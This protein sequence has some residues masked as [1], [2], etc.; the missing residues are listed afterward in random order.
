MASISPSMAESHPHE[1]G[2]HGHDRFHLDDESHTGHGS[3][4]SFVHERT[5]TLEEEARSLEI[6]YLVQTSLKGP[7]ESASETVF[8]DTADHTK[9]PRLLV[10]LQ[11]VLAMK[12][13]C[14]H[15]FNTREVLS[16][17]LA[18][19]RSDYYKEL[20]SLREQLYLASKSQANAELGYFKAFEVYWF[21]PPKYIDLDLKEY[22]ENAIK[23]Q[24]RNL[25][26]ENRQLLMKVEGKEDTMMDPETRIK[27]V[28]KK[29]GSPVRL[30]KKLVQMVKTGVLL[31]VSPSFG[32]HA[33]PMS[34]PKATDE[35]KPT[36]PPEFSL[37]ELE[38]AANEAFP[39]ALLAAQRAKEAAEAEAQKAQQ[40]AQKAAEE[41]K[42]KS[43]QAALA[44]S[45][46]DL[47]PVQKATGSLA[48]A[49]ADLHVTVSVPASTSL[50]D[51]SEKEVGPYSIVPVLQELQR[52]IEGLS[53]PLAQVIEDKRQAE[54]AAKYLQ[55][56]QEQAD[57]ELA[58]LTSQ[59]RQGGFGVHHGDAAQPPTRQP[60]IATSADDERERR[61]REE[62]EK[63]AGREK[64]DEHRKEFAAER[65][66]L[67]DELDQERKAAAKAGEEME[68]VMARLAQAQDKIKHLKAE[69]KEW[70]AK[71]G[72]H[73]ESEEEEEEEEVLPS[74]LLSY[75]QRLALSN[76]PRWMHLAEDAKLKLLRQQHFFE[77]N[78]FVGSGSNL[79]KTDPKAAAKSALEF[80]HGKKH[81]FPSKMQVPPGM[82]MEQL[83]EMA[84]SIEL[85]AAKPQFLS[86]KTADALAAEA[87]SLYQLLAGGTAASLL[88]DQVYS[89]SK[90]KP[91][92][93][94]NSPQRGGEATTPVGGGG[95]A[96][97]GVLLKKSPTAQLLEGSSEYS[98]P[99][100][101]PAEL[102]VIGEQ[103]PQSREGRLLHAMLQT[104]QQVA[105]QA[106]AVASQADSEPTDSE[107]FSPKRSNSPSS[108]KS[109]PQRPAPARLRTPPP[110]E[111]AEEQERPS[112][113]GQAGR[114]I[115]APQ[116]KARPTQPTEPRPLLPP[117]EPRLPQ[118][119][120]PLKELLEPQLTVLS[121]Q[122]PPQFLS[123]LPGQ[124]QPDPAPTRSP[125]RSHGPAP[126]RPVPHPEPVR[127]SPSPELELEITTKSLLR[128]T[129]STMVPS[130]PVSPLATFAAERKPWR[131][132]ASLPGSIDQASPSQGPSGVEPGRPARQF[133][134]TLSELPAGRSQVQ[135]GRSLVD[136]SSTWSPDYGGKVDR[137]TGASFV[138]F[139][140][141]A[142]SPGH[143]KLFHPARHGGFAD[144]PGP[145]SVAQPPAWT[146]HGA[147]AA[148]ELLRGAP[149]PPS[150]VSPSPPN[151][152]GFGRS[153]SA[154]AFPLT[155]GRAPQP[156]TMSSS[157]VKVRRIS[158]TV[159]L[160]MAN[161]P[162]GQAAPGNGF[163]AETLPPLPPGRAKKAAAPPSWLLPP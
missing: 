30:F 94:D 152:S 159:V 126:F 53:K 91:T 123:L 6:T 142:L 59:L 60:G 147:S 107:A 115:S 113:N 139:A 151:A 127:Q 158:S 108:Q 25:I 103:T 47:A 114:P 55:D 75:R 48:K 27:E 162:L 144:G 41:A 70:K 95:G 13:I 20:C 67:Q 117:T 14:E 90:K 29:I 133:T 38:A 35:E 128:Q 33:S 88:Q 62:R 132:T 56:R 93:R 83:Q 3:D 45:G 40:V 43:E 7:L 17:M 71:A 50:L 19:C 26:E 65:Q 39:Q 54:A 79:M 37:P 105:L 61:E 101:I 52:A 111:A 146:S 1:G 58:K 85:K 84:Q 140:D 148:D 161:A 129:A 97:S 104:A 163:I 109:S 154:T 22:L 110:A 57:S 87:Q 78:H 86:Q 44:A 9:R 135:G 12:N 112:S 68:V 66:R 16:K 98:Q 145:T 96:F 137:A 46:P 21:N 121:G 34:S 157:P 32:A 76:K 4:A 125:P 11:S 102:M 77:Q 131:E 155:N 10:S 15:E 150:L 36:I 89:I 49:V 8:E 130:G 92:S 160:P 134:S 141:T 24:S 63:K 82:S 23:E 122:P 99:V 28:I 69:L 106:A 64:E 119:R 118:G 74:Y 153:R 80:L 42:T 143:G 116:H 72:V 51:F 124:T 149:D 5:H 73:V 156:Q 18:R 2:S 31:K 81:R 136:P 120:P 138:Q 100:E